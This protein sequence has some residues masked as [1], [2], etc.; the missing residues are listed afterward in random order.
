[1]LQLHPSLTRYVVGLCVASL[2]IGALAQEAKTPAV[3][4]KQVC[5]AVIATVMVGKVSCTAMLCNMGSER[6]LSGF[7]TKYATRGTAL[8]ADSFSAGVAAQLSTALKQT[9]CFNVLDAASLE[10]T[11][12]DMEALGRPAPP[13]PAVDHLVRA[14]V[15]K[16]ELVL[17]ESGLLGFRTVTATSSMAVDTKIVHAATG[18]VGEVGVYESSVVRKSS[19]V[20]LGIYRSGDDAAKRGTPFADVTR[21]V[22]S[23]AAMGL[24]TKLAGQAAA[25]STAAGASPRGPAASATP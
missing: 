19:G 18:A 16:V 24:A 3:D 20:D 9:G 23:K 17:D 14:S 1:M 12:K 15:T 7:L 13:T 21:D 2:S 25:P 4:G 11:R 6:G 5:P 8:D 10:Q 22:L